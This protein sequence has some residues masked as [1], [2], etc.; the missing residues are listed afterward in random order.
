MRLRAITPWPRSLIARMT[1]LSIVFLVLALSWFTIVP[2]WRFF[3]ED[4]LSLTQGNVRTEILNEAISPE[5]DIASL[6]GSAVLEEVAAVNE[7]FRYYVWRGGEE[8]SF[9]PPPQHLAKIPRLRTMLADTQDEAGR[10]YWSSTIDEGDTTTW[11]SFRSDHGVE[12]YYE[13]SGVDTA[14]EGP[15]SMFTEAIFFWWTTR[16]AL[17]AGGGVLL[18]AFIVLLLA[19]RS[20]R[21][22]ARAADAIDAT[23]DDH[24]LLPEQGLPAEVATLVRAINEMIRRV[25][26]AHEEQEMFLATAA[27]EL[28][29]PMAVLRTRL[30]ELPESNT[31]EVLRDDVRRMASLVDQLLRLMQIRN[32]HEL[33]DRVD[34]V[35]TA[36]DVVADRAPL[37]IARGVDIELDA[38]PKSLVVNGHRG[39]VGVAIANLVDNAISFSK[40]GDNLKVRVDNTGRVSVSDC[41]PGIPNDDLER[42][43]EPFAK[44]PPNRHGHGLGLA[45]VR[46]VMTAHGGEVS[47]R[48]ADG[49]GADF[50]L[51]FRNASPP[52]LA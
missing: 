29:T 44:S 45:I 30:E 20:L 23:T 34:L 41:G 46:A 12:T 4:P 26:A 37:S 27:H 14:I 52:Q 1:L 35:A 21:T 31:K 11:V 8:A 42:I 16:D 17:I 48:N 24:R 22:L 9:G 5:G 2:Y 32:S 36:R 33:P 10:M 13:I 39:L 19:A 47:A 18:I 51:Q 7:K 49:G 15:R 50:A 38:V 3:N 40:S 28:R 25:E 6:A 43:F